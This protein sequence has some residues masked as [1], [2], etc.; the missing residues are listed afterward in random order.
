MRIIM[1]DGLLQYFQTFMNSIR[2][3]FQS[4]PMTLWLLFI[5]ILVIIVIL[6]F[7]MYVSNKKTEPD[8]SGEPAREDKTNYSADDKAI[9]EEIERM[10]PLGGWI[11]E[12]LSRKGYFSVGELSLS[13]LRAL[14]F[15]KT[16]FNTYNYKYQ[17][18]WFLV[19]G[20][21]GSGKSSLFESGG[22]HLPLGTPDFSKGKLK[23]SCR[24]W[25]LQGG[26]Y[27]ELKGD[28][29]IQKDNAKSKEK[30]WRSFIV[31]LTRYRAAR[32]INGIILTIPAT[33]LYGKDKEST[34]RIYQRA[35]YISAKLA[36]AQS[37]FGL[38]I[39]VYIAVTKTD[40]IPGFQSFSKH[41]PQNN[42]NDMFGWSN[43][44]NV[45][46]AYS[47]AWLEDA[48]TTIANKLH[49]LRLDIFAHS[50]AVLNEHLETNDGVFVFPGELEKLKEPLSI[51]INALFKPSAYQDGLLFRGFYFTGD[52]GPEPI[53]SIPL[54]P[55]TFD[56]FGGYLEKSDPDDITLIPHPFDP[57][58][59]RLESN[60]NSKIDSI[61][62]ARPIVPT[63]YA[64]GLK[65]IY[66]QELFTKK[67][68]YEAG[69]AKPLKQRLVS[70]NRGIFIAKVA[71]GSFIV[72]GSFG[73][74]NAYDTFSTSR[75]NITPVL[76][77]MNFVLHEIRI[78]KKN[79]LNARFKS[80]D[81]FNLYTHQIIDMMIQLQRTDLFSI[82]VPASWFSHLNRDLHKSLQVA[83]KEIIIRSIANGLAVR[84]QELLY[85]R[86][87]TIDV[88][89]NITQLLLP[90]RSPEFLL[91]QRF[92]NGLSDLDH[93]VTMFNSL[94]KTGEPTHLK[95]LIAYTFNC[96]L[97]DSFWDQYKIFRKLLSKTKLSEL[98]LQMYQ[99]VARETLDVLFQN[100]TNAIFSSQIQNSLPS[101]L[102][103]FLNSLN[104]QTTHTLP[105]L[106]NLRDVSL[107]LAQIRPLLGE[108]GKT[109]MDQP[110]FAPGKDLETLFDRVDA[111]RLFGKNV[112]QYL[113]DKAAIGFNELKMHLL[114][115]N[116]IVL[117]PQT[118]APVAPLVEAMANTNNYP[119]KGLFEIERS[120]SALFS[121]SYMAA[122][123]HFS[124]TT[125]TPH[126]KM[127]YWD[128]KL[129]DIAYDMSKGFE[130]FSS[131][132]IS[133]FPII[134]QEN[135]KLIARQSLQ[136]NI[137][138]L[139]SQAQSF[140][141]LPVTYTLNSAEE[142]LRAKIEDF[143]AVSPKFIKLLSIVNKESVGIA[144]LDLRALLVENS[145]WLLDNVKKMMTAFNPYAIRDFSFS[146]WNGNAGAALQGFSVRDNADL[147]AYMTLQNQLIQKISLEF[148]KPI[149]T[150]LQ[151]PVFV[152]GSGNHALLRKWSRIVTQTENY[153]NR[154][155]GNSVQT[156]HD[157]VTKD[158]ATMDAKMVITSINPAEINN[159]SGDFFIETLTALKK[160]FRS[161]AEILQRQHAIAAYSKLALY[162]NQNLK[163][164]F[165]FVTSNL[166]LVTEEADPENIREFYRLYQDAGGNT[167][168]TLDQL[169]Q[170]GDVMKNCVQFFKAMDY[171]KQFFAS[172]LDPNG[173][174]PIPA[175]DF[176]VDFRANRTNEQGADLVVDWVFKPDDVTS[177]DKNDKVKNGRWT[178]GNE[179]KFSFRWPDGA[180]IPSY[181][182]RDPKQ[183]N[184]SISDRT[185]TFAFKGKWSLLWALRMQ[186][187]INAYAKLTS[188]PNPTLMK[189][190]IPTGPTTSSVLFNTI[191]LTVPST[192]AHTK[193]KDMKLPNFPAFAPELPPANELHA[194]R[195]VLTEQGIGGIKTT[196]GEKNTLKNTSPISMSGQ[197]KTNNQAKSPLEAPVI[198]NR[199]Q[200]NTI[201]RP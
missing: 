123:T 194:D 101:R 179:V 93:Y 42:K 61:T 164:K 9:Y 58:T 62:I 64:D 120:L 5:C 121:E 21:E 4:V 18:P 186:E 133:T 6:L 175:F 137:I 79:P 180:K 54:K 112:T 136:S 23:A 185:A 87:K 152:D 160:G 25:F 170:L 74:F 103:T 85:L 52:A 127:I 141:D 145:F 31:L 77:N 14:S 82:F 156:L 161:R 139:L 195:A 81:Q 181:P 129:I 197:A 182:V 36:A 51:Y 196:T 191:A 116:K 148:A 60:A 46:A 109:W 192:S 50:G 34:E 8:K 147:E 68:S 22:L 44:Y 90:L 153:A 142:V 117:A 115:I 132:N 95:A 56:Q 189:F 10:P 102:T 140:V 47:P 122:P 2:L 37:S 41:V 32:P 17:V 75:N 201:K 39:P 163:G 113:V 19:L 48:F 134:L 146:W 110:V 65:L 76:A 135:I 24:W 29:F 158:L 119:S 70:L 190:T 169:Y 92:I 167:E 128:P 174:M 15:L 3:G 71:T 1:G 84:A 154:I 86:P 35:E 111:S 38:R 178:Y 45:M 57:D 125:T 83:F 33:E 80:A 172:Y 166:S 99:S 91:L 55:D 143:K 59:I 184:L 193:G 200:Q 183:P 78:D 159:D 28:L 118:S 69:L 105:D 124:F 131:K 168:N 67:I 151:S 157:F 126:G 11:S 16:T 171:L 63:E 66:V 107:Q 96:E 13:F 106:K 176:T 89:Q 27:I 12:F 40:I 199:A 155:A 94:K 30:M 149:V 144:F 188:K 20:T 43:P 49:Q 114:A 7:I 98:N 173:G 104:Q 97:P 165:P 198:S 162:F 26:V 100:F 138:S 130:N 108:V 53:S 177:I 150:F 73:L 72:V 88:T 187:D